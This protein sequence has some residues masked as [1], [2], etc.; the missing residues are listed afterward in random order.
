MYFVYTLQSLIDP[1]RYYIGLTANIERRLTEHN[2]GSNIHTNK[3]RP[4]NLITYTAF[5]DKNK[6][7]QFEIYLKSS[8][9]R[10]FAKKRL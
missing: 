8:S 6:A 1:S 4:W 3:F 9:G 5:F 10:A 2:E 7:E